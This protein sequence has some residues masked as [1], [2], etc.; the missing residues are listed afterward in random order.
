MPS[1]HKIAVSEV[2]DMNG[3]QKWAADAARRM[4][5]PAEVFAALP[6]ITLTG[7][8]E[9]TVDLQQGLLSFSDTEIA[10]R[11]ALGRVVVLGDEL[12]IVLMKEGRI[13]VRG[14]IDSVR[15]ESERA[16]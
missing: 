7:F 8:D 15:L 2:S 6:Q 9:I 12:R 14:R 1:L 4:D 5:L 13:S 11:V 3:M 16:Q 10:V